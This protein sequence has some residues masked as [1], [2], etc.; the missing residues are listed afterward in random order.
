MSY[1]S[2]ISD[3]RSDILVTINVVKYRECS[4]CYVKCNNM[5]QSWYMDILKDY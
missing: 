3:D 2:Y 5:F 1:V 4:E